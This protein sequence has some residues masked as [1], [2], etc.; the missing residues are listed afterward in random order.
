MVVTGTP[1]LK[2]GLGDGISSGD[3]WAE[4]AGAEVGLVKNT[5]QNPVVTALG[6]TST[7][8][9]RT[10][11]FTTGA[12]LNGY[13]LNSIGIMF[14][15][16]APAAGQDHSSHLTVTLNEDD[17]G[18]P[19]DALC[20]LSSPSFTGSGVQTFDAPATCPTLR[21]ARPTSWSSSGWISTQPS[22]ICP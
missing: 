17:S 10:Q 2:L 4:Y 13:A 20:T 1:R 5:G 16:I 3:R 21:R 22:S 15:Q 18:D 6:L 19:G 8:T 12:S 11:G 14:H 9:K 7:V